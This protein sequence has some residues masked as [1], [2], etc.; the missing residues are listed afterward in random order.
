VL[1]QSFGVL[2]VNGVTMPELPANMISR[3]NVMKFWEPFKSDAVFSLK[4]FEI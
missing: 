1:E 2:P 4:H 3:N